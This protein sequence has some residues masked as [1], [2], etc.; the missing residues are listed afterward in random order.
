MAV[1]L[2]LSAGTAAAQQI[3]PDSTRAAPDTTRAA[4]PAPPPV[5]GAI[6]PSEIAPGPL[7][8]GS[9]I[10]FSRDSILWTSKY[11]LADLLSDVPGVTAA[12]TGYAGEP[13][14]VLYGGRGTAGIELFY[15]GVPITA[16]GVDS[17]AVDP[18]RISLIGLRRVEVE[19]HPA[20]LRVYLV[21]EREARLGARSYLRILNGDF[22]TA[23]YAGVFQYRWRSGV[24]LDLSAD[25]LNTKGGQ[26]DTRNARWFDL[27]A[28][29]DWTPSPL[30]SASFQ[31]G[32]QTQDRE[33]T[34]GQNGLSTPLRNDRRT[35]S[36]LRIQGST[37]PNRFG[38]SYEAGLQSTNWSADSASADTVLGKRTVN[39]VFAG[40]RVSNGLAQAG[41]TVRASD[42][43]TPLDLEFTAGWTPLPWLVAAA[44]GRRE[45]HTFDRKSSSAWGSLGLYGGPLSLVGDI[46]WADAV[47]AP[48]LATDTAQRTFD[49]GARLGFASR[50]VTVHG[51]LER[52]DGFTPPPITEIEGLPPLPPAPPATFFVGDA[53]VQY[54]SLILSGTLSQPVSGE[55]PAFEPPM[56]SRVAL[57]FRSNFIKKFRSGAFDLKVQVAVESWGAGSAGQD[58]DGLPVALPGASVADAFLQ[59][60]LANFHAF[61]SLTNF[62]R[63]TETWV[64]GFEYP[65]NRQTF[66]VKWVF[67]N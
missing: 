42:Y 55:A 46:R 5:V 36:L 37:R 3:V 35:E 10:V 17:I 39:R 64:P 26:G 16:L 48:V 24:G 30:L 52:R 32:V 41:V 14:P 38:F 7:A 22:R 31:L 2:A 67:Q 57:T 12:R 9:R 8:P 33:A 40:L 15:D 43:H 19:R 49:L 23:G 59:V 50:R 63:A 28:R 58:A 21:S 61:Y 18:G 66:G 11:T 44:G 45:T 47:A 34:L 6:P 62:L 51:G 54:G 25:Y 56:H 53:S 1:M 29:S 65:R 60:E 20:F 4:P 27:R 13:T